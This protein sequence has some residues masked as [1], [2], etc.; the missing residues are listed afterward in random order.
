MRGSLRDP[1]QDLEP[2]HLGQ[3]QVQQDHLGD[4]FDPAAG[5]RP[6]AEEELQRLRA[7]ASDLDAVAQVGLLERAQRQLE[8]VGVVLD[9]Q[10]LDR[11]V[12]CS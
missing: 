11:A 3:L 8:V 12:R 6:F 2:V 5:V 7:V 9:E 1:P 4:V 10:D